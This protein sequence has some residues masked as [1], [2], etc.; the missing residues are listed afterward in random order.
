MIKTLEAIFENG[1]FKP[2]TY[3]EI[4]EH[5]KV[6]LTIEDKTDKQVDILSYAS[7]VYEDL[8]PKDISDIEDITYDRNNF[9]RDTK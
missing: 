1:V 3:P 2:L 8:S 6:K 5:K 4:P 7:M 9:S